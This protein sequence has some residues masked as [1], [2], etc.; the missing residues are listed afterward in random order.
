MTSD[1]L[2]Y[3]D[4]RIWKLSLKLVALTKYSLMPVLNRFLFFIF[5]VAAGFNAYSSQVDSLK[6]VLESNISP[7]EKCQTLIELGISYRSIN[8][9]TSLLFLHQATKLATQKKFSLLNF[10]AEI[11]MAGTHIRLNNSD[12]AIDQ[13]KELFKKLN[14]AE[15]KIAS[16]D[17]KKINSLLILNLEYTG[18]A[19][20]KAG[21]FNEAIHYYEEAEKLAE[22][23]KDTEMLYII[24]NDLAQTK[25]MQGLYPESLNYCLKGID[26]T[27]ISGDKKGM[28]SSTGN[29]GI[30]F[31]EMG[32]YK[33][34]IEYFEKALEINQELGNKKSIAVNL[35]NIGVGYGHLGDHQKSIFYY[36]K[37]IKM[38]EEL[39]DEPGLIYNYNNLAIEY[40]KTKKYDLALVYF[41]KS[42]EIL[43][44]YPDDYTETFTH[45]S[46]AGTLINKG[47]YQTAEEHLLKA[48][49]TAEKM[50]T[51]DQ[52]SDIYKAMYELYFNQNDN[53]KALVYYK[54][55]IRYRDTIINENSL[56]STISSEENFKYRE[57]T[58]NDSLLNVKEEELKNAEIETKNIELKAQQNYMYFMVGGLILFIAFSVLFYNRY[59]ISKKQNHI[60]YSQK[61]KV[62]EQN[63][64]IEKQKDLIEE[65]ATELSAR[66]KEIIDSINY[67][68]RIQRAI[69][70]TETEI[71]KYLPQTFLYYQPKDIVAG[72]FYFFEVTE[73]YIFL[74]A[75]DCTGHGVP[76][77]LMSVVCANALNRCIHEFNLCVAAEILDKTREIVLETLRKSGS[78]IKDGMDISFAVLNRFQLNEN[79]ITL[80]WSGA[81]NDLWFIQNSKMNEIAA[82]KQSIG[83]NYHPTPFTNHHVHLNKGDTFYLFTDGYA[84]QFG[85]PKG[86][87]FKYANLQKLLVE[88]SNLELETLNFKLQTVFN[89]WKAWPNP[90]GGVRELEQVDD[91][92]VIGIRI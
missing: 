62:E 25:Y 53:E 16:S 48:K 55:F 86:K 72:D 47:E 90:E 84:D 28:A 22:E 41:N 9:D 12:I 3:P 74:A 2:H 30:L 52:L 65:K 51:L 66:Q 33:K 21:K 81:N 91:V 80:N 82:D 14:S 85:G 63:K 59:T 60:I 24:Y 50:N 35:G 23:L 38:N 71:K 49:K 15:K 29:A 77:A 10:E 20:R 31:K 44:K 32:D 42:F 11:E 40:S 4:C 75:A 34:A 7:K 6:K 87:K 61:I 19:F 5:F 56:R 58:R 8:P 69:L 43:E 83:Q 18:N 26:I 39:G 1:F 27:T 57:K 76:G 37:A 78:E 64:D 54:S 73:K 46:I 79:T 67:A 13:L 70:T 45:I 88:N 92:C 89:E 36:N 17:K 68:Q